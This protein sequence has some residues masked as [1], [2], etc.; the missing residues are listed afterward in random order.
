LNI[1]HLK[2]VVAEATIVAFIV[3]TVNGTYTVQTT[4]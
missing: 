3:V 2:N 1:K 4:V